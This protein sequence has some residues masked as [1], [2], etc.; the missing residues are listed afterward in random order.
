MEICLLVFT[1]IH[2]HVYGSLKC[3]LPQKHREVGQDTL[4]LFHRSNKGKQNWSAAWAFQDTLPHLLYHSQFDFFSHNAVRNA[5]VKESQEQ[6][7][8]ILSSLEDTWDN[9]HLLH[10]VSSDAHNCSGH[11]AQK[12]LALP[13]M[14]WDS[15]GHHWWWPRARV[16]SDVIILEA[17][18]HQEKVGIVVAG[19]TLHHEKDHALPQQPAREFTGICA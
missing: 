18:Q 19:Q 6:C 11:R 12:S 17:L 7:G 2:S 4:P 9:G 14:K 10:K 13:Q 16:H 15:A 8:I 3:H 1:V 5:Y